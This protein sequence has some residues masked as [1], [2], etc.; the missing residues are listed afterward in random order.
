MP[1]EVAAERLGTNRN[2]LYKLIHDARLKLKARMARD[3]M[4][5]DDLDHG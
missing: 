3:G 1:L 2:A 5:M 4:T